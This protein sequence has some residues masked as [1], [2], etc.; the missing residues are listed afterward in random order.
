M[1][2]LANLED[3]QALVELYLEFYKT[4][5][6][7]RIYPA[8]RETIEK[9]TVW[10]ITEG[11]MVVFEEDGKILGS[12]GAWIGPA[13]F[14]MHVRTATEVVYYLDP[15]A[16]GHR[17]APALLEALEERCNELGAISLQMVRLRTSP[18]E[19]DVLYQMNG[20]KPSESYFTK[21]LID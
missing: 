1:I 9:L 6:Y 21:R 10:I 3:T 5:D 12:A 4:T 17:V 14:N 20:Y 16:R 7:S 15:T 19:V 8:D 11:A 13:T 18:A 2:R